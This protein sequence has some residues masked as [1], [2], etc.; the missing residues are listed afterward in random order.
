[1]SLSIERRDARN[2]IPDSLL[3]TVGIMKHTLRS[4]RYLEKR[5]SETMDASDVDP[6]LRSE[7]QRLFDAT[8][9]VRVRLSLMSITVTEVLKETA[10]G[11]SADPKAFRETKRH[12]GQTRKGRKRLE[13]V[14]AAGGKP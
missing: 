10:T 5:L 3:Q 1:M 14:R 13:I 4:M 8:S 2:A 6:R 12:Q 9:D 11:E 7:M